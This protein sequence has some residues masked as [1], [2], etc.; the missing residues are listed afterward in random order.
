M[1]LEY[2]GVVKI[3]YLDRPEGAAYRF[4]WQELAGHQLR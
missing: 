4:A 2:V 3:Q 1:G